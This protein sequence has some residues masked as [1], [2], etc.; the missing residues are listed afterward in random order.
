MKRKLW[1]IACV[2]WLMAGA[3]WGE[4]IRPPEAEAMPPVRMAAP[5]YTSIAQAAR[6]RGVVEL[7]GRVAVDGTLEQVAVTKRLPMGLTQGAEEAAGWWRFPTESAGARVSLE[8]EFLLMPYERGKKLPEPQIVDP[9]RVRIHGWMPTRLVNP[10]LEDSLLYNVQCG[11]MVVWRAED[12][13]YG[14]ALPIGDPVCGDVNPELVLHPK[15]GKPVKVRLEVART[16]D[17]R[18][19]GLMHREAL[20]EDA[21]MLFIFARPARL[22]FWM[23]DTPLPLDI[24][25]ITQDHKVLG[26]VENAEPMTDTPRMVIGESQF[27]LEVNAGFSRRHGIVEGTDVLFDGVALP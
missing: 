16:V 23:R 6:I 26:I 22:S 11:Q 7:T 21:G 19:R 13:A 4:T 14:K 27:V 20:D 18:S 3:L 1:T 2:G 12:G 25:F 5:A 9:F 10:F 15:G 8:F 24:L 17:A